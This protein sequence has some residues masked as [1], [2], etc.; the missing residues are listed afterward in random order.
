MYL[1]ILYEYVNGGELWKKCMYYGIESEKLIIYY[2]IQLLEGIKHM[3]SFNIVHRD[4]KVK[5]LYNYI[6]I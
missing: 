1:Y 3:H 4:I 6:N 2:F 5:L